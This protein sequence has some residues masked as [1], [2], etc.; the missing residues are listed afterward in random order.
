MDDM[1][2]LDATNTELKFMQEKAA[3]WTTKLKGQHID[4]V[5]KKDLP[6]AVRIIRPGSL[7]TKDFQ[8]DR[9]NIHLDSSGIVS[10]VQFG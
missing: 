6:S 4:S 1:E 7:V 8:T 10:H 9:M 5:D 2:A 3:R